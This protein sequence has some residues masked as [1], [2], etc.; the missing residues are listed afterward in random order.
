MTMRS[1]STAKGEI[2]IISVL[3]E[4]ECHAVPTSRHN[5]QEGISSKCTASDKCACVAGKGRLGP[6]TEFYG[7]EISDTILALTA[8]LPFAV[9][10]IKSVN[11]Y[12]THFL[13]VL[14]RA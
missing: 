5:N 12:P 8:A 7:G 1:I 14:G 9:S 4:V 3:I 11:A 6:H 2:I 10:P 13:N